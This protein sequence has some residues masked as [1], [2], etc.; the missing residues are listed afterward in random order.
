[1]MK[2]KILCILLSSVLALS[3]LSSCGKN[4]T[5]KEAVELIEPVGVTENYAVVE[6]RDL[7]S[8]QVY[9][10]RMVPV[11]KDV[12]F[13]SDQTFKS[14]GSLPGTDVKKGDALAI[15]STDS[16][17]DR[18]KAKKEQM[19]DSE[20]SFDEFLEENN[21][22][23]EGEKKS[24]PELAK[25]IDNFES[26]TDEE[27]KNYKNYESEYKKYLGYYQGTQATIDRLEQ[28][29]KER[30][31]LYNLD[32]D[33]MK[34]ELNRLNSKRNDILATAPMD[35]TV[36]AVNL[37]FDG[38]WI[39]KE[40][41]IGK[42]GDLND[43][44]VKTEFVYKAE[45]KK[46]KEYYAIYN[47]KR[48]EALFMEDESAISS[49]ETDSSS[50]FCV[51]DP[52]HEIPVGS[53][54]VIIVVKDS[55]D[56]VLCVPTEA[57][58]SDNDGSFVYK[59]EGEVNTRTTISTGLKSG[60]YTE[61]T[62]GLNEGDKIVSE[63]KVAAK[64]GTKTLEKGTIK[65]NFTET[66]FIYYSKAEKVK[67]PIE[68]GTMYVKNVEVN[69]Y[70]RVTKGQTIANVWVTGDDIAIRRLERQVL[71]ATEDLNNLIKDGEEANKKSIKKQR[72]YIDDLNKDIAQKKK[73]ASM[74]TIVAPFDGIITDIKEYKEGDIIGNGDWVVT[75]SSENNC[76]VI[77]EDTGKLTYGNKVNIEYDANS[78]R[79][80][81]EGTVVTVT[82]SR[83][84]NGYQD[85]YYSL[86]RVS[87]EDMSKMSSSNFVDGWWRR[88]HFEIQADIRTMENVVLVPK[89]A[90]VQE[91]G[92]TYVTVLDENGKPS[93]KSFI[94]G[95]SDTLNYWV[96]DGLTEGT[97]ICSD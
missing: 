38:D 1:M 28:N 64:K 15:A 37:M 95:G 34:K 58:S 17:D 10:G 66:G 39:S 61:I 76:F 71:R 92:V 48:Y 93:Y 79:N 89:T 75:I 31:E 2:K 96:V 32:M 27:K 46:A 43:L 85:Q 6:R 3:L 55:R 62:G 11:T 70:E 5:A 20:K 23:L 81:C 25:I 21:E 56:D 82:P 73:D 77:V 24:L 42:V 97:V 72:E 54:V 68:S 7:V 88:S 45:I 51:S 19:E 30:T 16:I 44:R 91:N 84:G 50:S 87:A 53:F 90:V 78:T 18:I 35:G 83:Y 60:L 59:H 22:Q 36:V 14:Y 69:Q 8:Y 13:P 26:M 29:I 80:T 9:S 4:K 63:F 12:K 57:I 49:T 41:V 40:N 67:N 52:N 94:S 47:G 65:A 86:I 33:Y 74:T